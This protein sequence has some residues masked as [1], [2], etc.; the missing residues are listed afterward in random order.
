[1]NAANETHSSKNI[2]NNNDTTTKRDETHAPATSVGFK[3][4]T[5]EAVAMLP[6][7]RATL[8]IWVLANQRSCARG[9]VQSGARTQH[10]AKEEK[11]H[12]STTDTREGNVEGPPVTPSH[13]A[14][15]DQPHTRTHTHTKVPCRI[16]TH[17]FS[18]GGHGPT[19]A[20]SFLDE[21]LTSQAE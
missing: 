13:Y 12:V 2:H 11:C 20:R 8:R 9:E 14:A 1:M 18:N 3:S 21:G 17:H 19:G 7:N 16:T 5:G 6:A 10:N 4:L 15:P